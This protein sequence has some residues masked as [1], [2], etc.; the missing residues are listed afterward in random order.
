[1]FIPAG[2]L[3]QILQGNEDI[4]EKKSYVAKLKVENIENNLHHVI[5]STERRHSGLL[6]GCLY[7]DADCKTVNLLPS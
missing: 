3:S 1:M 4:E 6:G 2:I 5:N 7:I